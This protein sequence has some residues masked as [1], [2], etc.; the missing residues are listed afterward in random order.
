LKTHGVP[1]PSSIPPKDKVISK[2]KFFGA[3]PV[4]AMVNLFMVNPN[5]AV[6]SILNGVDTALLGDSLTDA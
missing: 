5:S 4:L 3:F 6:G 2:S 1:V